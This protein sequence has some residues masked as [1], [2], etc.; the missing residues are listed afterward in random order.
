[1]HVKKLD[2]GEKRSTR[3]I[4]AWR[5]SYSDELKSLI[6]YSYWKRR[7]RA[8][9]ISK[10]KRCHQ[11]KNQTNQDKNLMDSI[12]Y[13]NLVEKHLMGTIAGSW[14]QSNPNKDETTKHHFFWK[15]MAD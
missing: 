13:Y 14:G 5:K 1:M 9:L 12:W 2:K 3:K 11:K 6:C 10:D 4:E 7:L 15:K 8:D